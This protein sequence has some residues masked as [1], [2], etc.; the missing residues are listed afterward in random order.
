MTP[1]A[2]LSQWQ[3]MNWILS[4][5]LVIMSSAMACAW[6]VSHAVGFL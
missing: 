2:P 6:A 5:Y 1:V 4:P 3:K